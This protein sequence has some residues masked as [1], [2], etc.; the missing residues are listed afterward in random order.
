MPGVDLD[1]SAALLESHGTRPRVILVDVNVL[2]YAAIEVDADDHAMQFGRGSI[3]ALR[4]VRAD[5]PLPTSS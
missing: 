4:R 2:V 5:W 3:D 1:D